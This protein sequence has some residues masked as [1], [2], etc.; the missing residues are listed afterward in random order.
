MLAVFLISISLLSNFLSYN[1][2]LGQIKNVLHE[3]LAKLWLV[4][5]FKKQTTVGCAF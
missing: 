1:D 5:I 4:G 2:S 3:I